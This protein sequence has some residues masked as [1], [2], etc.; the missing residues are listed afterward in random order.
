MC[1]ICHVSVVGW[2]LSD[3]KAPSTGD[4][5]GFYLEYQGKSKVNEA[6]TEAA[7]KVVV[8]EEET[9]TGGWHLFAERIR[10]LR[11]SRVLRRNRL[12][13]HTLLGN[14]AVAS[15]LLA[16]SDPEETSSDEDMGDVDDGEGDEEEAEVH[17]NGA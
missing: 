15:L 11:A 16:H 1:S 12:L 8:P 17:T 3:F 6:V 13:L 14:I 7:S 5:H 9:A 2:P 4:H 10:Q